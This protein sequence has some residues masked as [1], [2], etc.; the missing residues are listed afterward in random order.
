MK[1]YLE[2]FLVFLKIGCFTFGGGYA[3]IPIVERELIKKKGWIPLEEVMDYY[4][5]GQ[6]IPGIIG[7]NLSTFVGYKRKGPLGGILAP[8][9]F[10]LP[11]V[12]LILILA[13]F[14][15]NFADIPMVQSAFAGIRIVVGALILDTVIKLAKGVLKNTQA[16]IIFL[17]VFAISAIPVGI[18]PIPGFVRS[19]VFLVLA[20]GLAGFIIFKMK[21]PRDGQA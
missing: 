6:I 18:L 1:E 13:I 19:P 15:S 3:M 7:V 8:V 2:L 4:T 21:K 17:I 16:I 9:G 11:G 14:I 10:V 20:S 12:T 5:V